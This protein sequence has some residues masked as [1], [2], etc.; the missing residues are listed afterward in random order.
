MMKNPFDVIKSEKNED[1][2]EEIASSMESKTISFTPLEVV[3]LGWLIGQLQSIQ[4]FSDPNGAACAHAIHRRAE[5]LMTELGID[6]KN[7]KMKGIMEAME[8]KSPADVSIELNIH[9][10]IPMIALMVPFH[11]VID[12]KGGPM[13]TAWMKLTVFAKEAIIE[14]A[15]KLEGV[16]AT[17]PNMR[18]AQA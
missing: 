18:P 5:N 13:K 3:Q 4:A 16:R 15:Q 11:P 14:I 10:A 1:R 6:Y 12:G 2:I 17:E 8:A 9:D 7:L